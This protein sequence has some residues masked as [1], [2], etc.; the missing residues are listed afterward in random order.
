MQASNRPPPPLS[1]E[2]NIFFSRYFFPNT[3]TFVAVICGLTAVTSAQEKNYERSVVL[4]LFSG[5]FDGLDGPIARVLNAASRFGAELDSLCDY[6]NF[7]VAPMFVLYEWSMKEQGNWGWAACLTYVICMGCRLAR[8]NAGVDF[9]ASKATRAFF[10]GVPAPLGALCVLM[11]MI[12]SF[13]FG[14]SFD[15]YKQKEYLVPYV[16]FISF[17]LISTLPTIS[18][19][20]LNRNLIPRGRNKV[21]FSSLVGGALGTLILL[22]FW[23]SMLVFFVLYMISI[24]FTYVY[25]QKIV[26]EEK[27]LQE[28][29]EEEEGSE[30]S[31]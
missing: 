13:V 14:D 31:E 1:R 4:I 19:K 27:L 12:A 26:R 15:S 8:F 2:R 29:E 24:P 21:V 17:L 23:K 20:G 28:E 10:M 6:V 25:F 5:I 30:N 9:N 11:P 3:V 22:T 7:G 16:F 18:S